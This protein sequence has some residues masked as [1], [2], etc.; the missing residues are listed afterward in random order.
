MSGLNK[1]ST[2]QYPSWYDWYELVPVLLSRKSYPGY[3]PTDRILFA[4]I[5]LGCVLKS[6]LCSF[7]MAIMLNI[8]VF[9]LPPFLTLLGTEKRVS[10]P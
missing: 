1:S 8:V 9:T 2:T 3:H 10:S 5:E 4:L 6:C 7:S